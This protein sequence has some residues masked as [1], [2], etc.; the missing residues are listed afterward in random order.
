ML[1]DLLDCSSSNLRLYSTPS[2][3]GEDKLVYEVLVPGSK[4]SDIKL[5]KTSARGGG[6]EVKV[7]YPTYPQRTYKFPERI[8]K[9]SKTYSLSTFAGLYEY[10]SSSLED[11]I[12]SV[13]LVKKEGAST[14]IIW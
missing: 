6:I 11:G 2:Q 3:S 8:D 14:E 1:L 7:S 12:L 9:K 13:I 5:L 10:E 4:K